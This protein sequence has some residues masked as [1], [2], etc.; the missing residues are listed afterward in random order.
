MENIINEFRAQN[1]KEAVGH[2]DREVGGHCFS[3]CLAMARCGYLYHAE[4]HLLEGWGEA[5]AEGSYNGDFISCARILVFDA[6]GKSDRHRNILL[7]HTV[8]AFGVFTNNHKMYL[9]IRGR[10]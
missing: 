3:H 4:P 5:V 7:D 9:T 1:G 8:L 2:F 10:L 6:L